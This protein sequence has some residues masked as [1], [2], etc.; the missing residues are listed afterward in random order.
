MP[1]NTETVDRLIALTEQKLALLRELRAALEI[2]ERAGVHPDDIDRTGY[3]PKTDE[4]WARWPARETADIKP[5][6]NYVILK[7]GTRV[8][9]PIDWKAKREEM[10]KARNARLRFPY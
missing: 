3:D 4:R 6:T 2:A 9:L 1:K 8:E 5:E 7:D 10:R